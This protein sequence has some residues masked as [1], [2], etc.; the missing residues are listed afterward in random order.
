MSSLRVMEEKIRSIID[1]EIQSS[2]GL[3]IERREDPLGNSIY[4]FFLTR[5]KIESRAVDALID[6]TNSWIDIILNQRKFSRFVDKEVTS[7]LL[8]FYALK[9]VGRLR[10]EVDTDK[11][12][13]LISEFV[14]DD[15]FFDNFTYTTLILFSLVKQRSKIP[16]FN[17]LF[18]GIRRNLHKEALFNDVKNLIF[19]SL[20][21]EAINAQDDLKRLVR[22]CFEKVEKNA[23]RFDDR[24]YYAWVLWYNRRIMEERDLPKIINFT[25]DALENT[26]RIFG[27][28][29]LDESVIE[30]YGYD[31]EPEK[32]PKMLLG[33]T[34]DLLISFNA[35]RI[36]FP[37]PNIVYIEQKLSSLGWRE[38]WRELDKALEGFEDGRM[39]DCCNNL[40]M[41][42][43]IVWIKVCEK[44]EGKPIPTQVGKTVDIGPLNKCLETHG[45]PED[46]IGM[47]SRTWSYVSDRAHIEK[48][49]GQAPSELEVRYGIQ[50]A[51][52]T[53]E[54]LLRLV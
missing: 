17:R 37:V 39:S 4:L 32:F 2:F 8:G 21:L 11:L 16:M 20:L 31:T 38:A 47:V 6:W 40:R 29:E 53:I 54:H 35:S 46:T 52:A 51:F 36:M 45:L 3:E 48:R 49:G 15:S 12:V 33:T 34:L 43:I 44:L 10:I 28:E 18:E 1:K 9:S 7:A 50:L 23:V 26:A 24:V 42:L 30:M 25:K 41:G 27:T 22:A 14:T 19:A 5:N 13:G